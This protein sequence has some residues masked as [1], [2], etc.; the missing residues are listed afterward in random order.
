MITRI[1]SQNL[2]ALGI[3]STVITALPVEAAQRI[4]FNYNSLSFSVSVDSLA[5]FAEEGIVNEELA[6][7]LGRVSPE[8]QNKFRQALN[9]T[10]QVSPIQ[11]YH[12]FTTPMGEEFLEIVGSFINI[13][14]GRNGKYPLRGALIQAASEPEGLSLLNVMR[15]FSTNMEIN[16]EGIGEASNLVQQLIN[17][18]RVMLEEM[19][20]LTAEEA[21]INQDV[22]FSELPDLRDRGK[23]TVEKRTL[24]LRDE[25]RDREFFV[26][27]YQPTMWREGAVPVVIISHG[28]ASPP[29]DLGKIARHLA[30][31][32]YLVALPQH[33][34]SDQIQFQRMLN[35]E[36]GEIFKL[37]DFID[38]PL[39]ISYVIDELERLNQSEFEGRLNLTEVGVAGHS[40][41]GYTALAIAGA[42]LNFEQLEQACEDKLDEP[43]MS[44]LLQCRALE[45]DQDQSYNFRDERVKAIFIMNPFNSSIF[46]AE[47]LS[48]VETPVFMVGGSQD[49]ATPAVLEQINSFPWLPVANKYL[50]LIEG[51]AHVDFSTLD[52]GM[53]ALVESIPVL[54]V[55]DQILIDSYIY[56]LSVAFFETYVVNNAEYNIYLTSAYAQYIS[57]EPS[58][59]YMITSSSLEPL[60]NTLNSL[61]L[62]E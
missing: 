3:V 48:Y 51:D 62:T 4:Y 20:A 26:D 37:N 29:K 10:Y 17:A 23:F 18:T 36:A 50:A 1:W 47:G 38:R 53:L 9:T 59:L 55:P 57:K 61:K 2:L 60:T 35:G 52:A 16:T 56:S 32:G 27:I 14:G 39:D 13:Q 30:S 44:L 54:T 21:K 24:N 42:Q 33:S 25:S 28:L 19:E 31:H 34:G 11:I 8:N 46:G 12:F 15:K 45:L 40:F 22:N 58:S 7:Y 5:K 41:G 43:N 49:P 6:F